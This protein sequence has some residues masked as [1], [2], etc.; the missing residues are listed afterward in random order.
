MAG[1]LEGKVALVS[2]AARGQG[3][4]HAVRLAQEGADVIAFDLCGQMSTVPYPMATSD[5]LKETVQQVEEL[6]RRIVA[7]EADVRDSAAVKAVVDEGVAELGGRL[8]IV[9]ANAGICTFGENVW[10]L[11]DE[12]WDETIGVNLTGVFKTIRAAVPHMIQAGNGGSIVI[13]SSTAGV[14]GMTR[15]GHYVASKH[16]VVGLMRTLANE[17]AQYSIRVNTVHP[18]GVD[19]PMVNNDYM[20]SFLA[21]APEMAQNMQN[22]LPVEMVE[23]VDISNAIVWLCSDEAR[24]VT[25]ITVPVDAG[26]LNR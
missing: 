20:Q 13:T 19:T 26:F 21:D 2:G 24:Y 11:T 22:A 16:G 1:R 4:S 23:P 9:C 18:T 3:R 17:L 5:D 7:R 6:D 15:I 25:G 14:K 8:D 12:Q 10:S